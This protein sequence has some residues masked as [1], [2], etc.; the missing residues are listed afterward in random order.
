MAEHTGS[1]SNGNVSETFHLAG[2]TGPAMSFS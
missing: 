2:L 1:G